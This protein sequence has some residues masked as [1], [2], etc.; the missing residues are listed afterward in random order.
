MTGIE[1]AQSVRQRYPGIKVLF[2]TGYARI[3]PRNAA[4]AVVPGPVLRKPYR[5]QELAEKLRAVIDET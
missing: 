1:L 2:S 5:K 3:E 4:D